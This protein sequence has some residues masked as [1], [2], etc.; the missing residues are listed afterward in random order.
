MQLTPEQI[1]E[2]YDRGYVKIPGAISKAMV[3]TARQAVNHSIGTLGPNGEDMSKHRAAQFCRDLNGAPVIM[4]L[5]NASPVISLAESL[6]GEGNLQKPI[7]GAQ[8]APRF[9]TVIGEVPP[10]PRGHLDGMGTGTN[11]MPKGV[12][13]RGFTAFAVIYLADVPEPYSGNFTVWPGSHRFFENY[14]KREGLEILSN[15]TPRVDLPEGPDM[16]TGNAGDLII[17]HHQ[18][19]HTGGPN[20]SP[21]IRYAAIARLRHID[22]DKNGNEGFQDIWREFPCVREA[23]AA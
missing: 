23:V 13:R 7:R 14:L 20:A 18:M 12:Y 2:F 11:G 16:V 10:E 6:M 17:A 22:C 1:R 8:V 3:D 15:G 21:N 5:F 19:I 9:P 4:D